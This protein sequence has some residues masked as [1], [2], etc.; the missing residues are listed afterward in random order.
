MNSRDRFCRLCFNSFLYLI[1]G[2][3]SDCYIKDL[4][5]KKKEKQE[6][7]HW[8]NEISKKLNKNK[9]KQKEN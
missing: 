4:V 3:C 1:N 7:N 2:I 6:F 8:L 5:G 9:I